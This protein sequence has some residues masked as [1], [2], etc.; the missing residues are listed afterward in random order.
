[1]SFRTFLHFVELPTKVAS[2]FPFLVG[3]LFVIY[4]YEVF[5]P[6]NTIIFFL[7]MLIFDLTTTAI[8]NYMDYVKAT[9]DEYRKRENIIGQANIPI[10]LARFTIFAM[11]F[12]AIGL[13]IWLVFRTDLLVLFIG[14]ACF[15]IGIFYTY[16]P[17]PISRIPLGEVFSGV[18]MGF[19]IL[20]LTVYV[21]AYNQG[22][23][24]LFVNGQTISLQINLVLLS[25]ILLVSLPCIFTIANIMLANNIC[26]LDDDIKNR[27]FTLPYYIGKK[28]AV[29]LYNILY[30]G[31]FV[32]IL[33]AVLLNILPIILLLSLLIIVPVS[34]HISLFNKKQIKSETFSLA[35]KNLVFINGSIIAMMAVSF[36]V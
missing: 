9:T 19:G 8:N 18:T 5:D 1:M 6:I 33:A 34:R 13:G 2:L 16:G 15:I 32:A 23:A 7:A 26:D 25:E 21:N 3:L 17:V 35:I 27:R 4:R 24:N 31:S 36:I 29:A 22:I 28:K 14:L 20:F 11:L 30:A 10:G 12:T